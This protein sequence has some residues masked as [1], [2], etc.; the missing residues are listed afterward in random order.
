MSCPNWPRLL[1]DRERAERAGVESPSGWR[2]AVEHLRSCAACRANAVE[3]DPTLLFVAQPAL[4]VGEDEIDT[5][6]ANVRVLRRARAKERA[7]AAPRR[8][9]G[10]I[11]AAAAVGALM[12]LLPTH[13][14]RPPVPVAVL[15]APSPTPFVNGATSSDGPAPL[16]EPLDLPLAR[17][18]Q[19]GEED[20]SVVM[21]VD[22]SIDV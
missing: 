11:A 5:I 18:Y 19:L 15:P 6:R 20:L 8:R 10:R 2:A 13:T 16:I 17:I 7:T 12:L 9:L 4:E 21:V 3:L 14:S 1:T 22:E